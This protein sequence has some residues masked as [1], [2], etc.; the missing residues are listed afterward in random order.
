MSIWLSVRIWVCDKKQCDGQR[1]IR[2]EGKMVLTCG[3]RPAPLQL[4][5]TTERN[6]SKPYVCLQWG[7]RS[8]GQLSDQHL[9]NSSQGR[10]TELWGSTGTFETSAVTFLILWMCPEKVRGSQRSL[11]QSVFQTEF[12][13]PTPWL[14][15]ELGENPIPQSGALRIQMW[16]G[17]PSW[18]PSRSMILHVRTINLEC[19]GH[20]AE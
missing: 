7:R 12:F 4:R 13:L 6:T 8:L 15:E 1:L 20:S 5:G 19:A 2:L 18:R 10:V 9:I 14:P 11:I 16:G 3:E 17:D